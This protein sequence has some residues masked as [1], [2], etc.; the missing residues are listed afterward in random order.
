QLA[1]ADAKTRSRPALI[2]F[3]SKGCKY[4]R[5]LSDGAFSDPAV[6]EAAKPFVCVYVECDWG[7]KN[8]ELARRFKVTGYPIVQICNPQGED[9][10]VVQSRTAPE[11]AQELKDT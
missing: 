7:F 3:T 8:V 5:V 2:F 6:V 11:L 10:G 9:S 1:L 4:C